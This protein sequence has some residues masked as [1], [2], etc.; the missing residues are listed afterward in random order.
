MLL[1]LPFV[2]CRTPCFRRDARKTA[3]IAP[4]VTAPITAPTIG[5]IPL[6]ES[7]DFSVGVVPLSPIVIS[8]LKIV[9]VNFV[10]LVEELAKVAPVFD[11]IKET[12][13]AKC[14]P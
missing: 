14:F 11:G 2:S 12:D 10:P 13:V 5:P 6:D 8:I 3:T 7:P 4:R 9:Q 1:S